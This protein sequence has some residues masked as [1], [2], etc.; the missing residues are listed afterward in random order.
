[1]KIIHN[2]TFSKA[3]KQTLKYIA[4]DKP[5]ASLNFKEELKKKIKKLPDNP[6]MCPPSYYFKEN[7]VRDMTFKKYT[8]IYEIKPDEK[9][10]EILDIF[11]RN[12]P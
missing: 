12:K 2:P 3:L 11:N 7:N 1:M 9:V 5:I 10:I 4:N 8:I 6:Y